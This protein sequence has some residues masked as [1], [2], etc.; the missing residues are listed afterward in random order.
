MAKQSDFSSFRRFVC[1]LYTRQDAETVFRLFRSHERRDELVQS[2]DTLWNETVAGKP[3]TPSPQEQYSDEATRLVKRL[4][5]RERSYAVRAAWRTTYWKYAAVLLLCIV[6]GWAAVNWGSRSEP[7][8]PEYTEV[9]VP[10]GENRKVVLP[11]GTQVTLN[12]GSR[13]K[14]P[15][16]FA[17][18]SR[19]VEI[20]GEG[21][22]EVA[23]NE[24][25]PFVIHTQAAS[26]QVLGTSFN[27]QAYDADE[28]L[29]VCVKTGK[30]Q[31]SMPEGSMYLLPDEEITLDKTT[32]EIRK[33]KENARKATAWLTGTLYFNRTPVKSVA[34]QLERM[35]DCVIEF[36][37]GVS[38]EEY[39]YGEHDNKSLESV[40]NSI[41]YAT[42]IQ[43]EK[44]GR[45]I[46][47]YKEY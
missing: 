10:N 41:R 47:L 29:A 46:L 28:Q 8:A 20:N 39:V 32:R 33:G 37:P 12:A 14:Y 34:R 23:R 38:Y 43:Y 1:G 30:V 3:G 40:L 27:L 16:A 26:V 24:K 9:T 13:L 19:T 42:G 4:R 18:N 6:S 2:M 45:H 31:V 11:D 21:F 36:R 22:F 7:A 15:S 25:A 5:R 17:A 35:Y 44:E